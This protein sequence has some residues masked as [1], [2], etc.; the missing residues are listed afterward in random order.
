MGTADAVVSITLAAH[1]A[2]DVLWGDFITPINRFD[3][4]L[5]LFTMLGHK[6]PRDLQIQR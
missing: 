1:L 3:K 4:D 6:L 2:V 5:S